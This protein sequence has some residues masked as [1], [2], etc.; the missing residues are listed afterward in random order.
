MEVIITIDFGMTGSAAEWFQLIKDPKS[1]VKGGLIGKIPTRLAY[2]EDGKVIAFGDG[3]KSGQRIQEL[4]KGEFSTTRT[5]STRLVEVCKLISDYLHHFC[6][7]VLEEIENVEN[8]TRE[9][10][11]V[12]WHLTTPGSWTEPIQRNFRVLASRVL[13]GLLPRSKVIVEQT[14]A[15]TSCEYLRNQFVFD[16]AWVITCDIG[17]ATMDT[18]LMIGKDD[19]VFPIY[20]NDLTGGTAGVCKIDKAFKVGVMDSSTYEGSSKSLELE[21]IAS[22]IVRSSQ[23]EEARYSSDAVSEV[24]IQVEYDL[25]KAILPSSGI[26]IEGYTMRVPSNL[27]VTFFQQFLD[28]LVLEIDQGLHKLKKLAVHKATSPGV[29]ALCGGGG[30]MVYAINYLRMRY[31]KCEIRVLPSPVDSAL[32]T[33]R[34]HRLY[35]TRQSDKVFVTDSQLGLSDGSSTGAIQWKD[36]TGTT[37]WNFSSGDQVAAHHLFVCKKGTGHKASSLEQFKLN[38]G[39]CPGIAVWELYVTLDKKWRKQNYCIEVVCKG[40]GKFDFRA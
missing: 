10:L 40:V 32:A 31:S 39:K 18:A 7:H 17:G 9:I 14:E 11:D 12:E 30:T 2:E 24:S 23:W 36:S 38:P 20:H 5:D 4:F 16:S 21:K 29:I 22:D 19:E 27:M 28:A 3:C 13:Q 33:L 15:T 35:L 37:T 34:G 25:S 8:T 26:S 1:L 6:N